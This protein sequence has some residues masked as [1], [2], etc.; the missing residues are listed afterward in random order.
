MPA[1]QDKTAKLFAAYIAARKIL[2]AD[3]GLSSRT[4]MSKVFVDMGAKVSNI[5]LAA[6][7]EVAADALRTQK[8]SV[9]VADYQLDRG[10]SGLSLIQTQRKEFPT[11]KDVLFVLVTG[12]T[13][14]SAVAQAA[15]EDVDAY[16]LKPYTMGV[17]RQSIVRAAL[18]K[19]HPSEY[20]KAIDE[21]KELL[22][23]EKVDDAL[24]TFEK[25][26]GLDSKPA[27]ALA[28]MGQVNF[29]K[30]AMAA[31]EGNYAKGLGYSKIHYKCMVGLFDLMMKKQDFKGAYDTVKRISQYFPANPHRLAQ[32]LRLAIV[33]GSYEDIEKYYQVFTNIDQRNE[34]IIR[35]VCAALV[36][37][38]KFYLKSNARGRALELFEKA[39]LTATH[40][41]KVLRELILALIEHDLYKEAD[42]H[43]HRF[44]AA[45]QKGEDYLI[46]QYLISNQS[47]STS[48]MI[49]TG[50][51]LIKSGIKDPLV[52]KTL[53]FHTAK[54]GFQE[55]AESLA[56]EAQQLFPQ[57]AKDFIIPP[58]AVEAA[59]KNKKTA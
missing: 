12:N 44:P 9:V 6:N 26:A 51:K 32:V 10:N 59:E 18:N 3:C 42:V 5:I 48:A 1:E 58:E 54:A 34:E 45:S 8:P 19:A 37:C 15:E 31:S 17:L 24:V 41:T 28:Y 46:C 57:N 49:E 27:L 7:Y 52:Y 36:V 21:G 55:A 4:A 35:Y 29:I 20:I 22:K 25:A 16:V 23:N 43:L 47:F 14:Q 13:S 2:V 11:V 53:L 39:A 56:K 50:R 30:E 40:K 33:T 38:G